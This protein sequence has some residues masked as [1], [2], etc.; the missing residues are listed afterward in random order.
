MTKKIILL[1]MIPLAVA[2]AAILLFVER[3]EQSVLIFFVL[4][5]SLLWAGTIY[6]GEALQAGL[7]M[8]W[9]L[10][11]SKEW[12]REARERKRRIDEVRPVQ[13]EDAD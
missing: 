2:L 12:T 1:N 8:I 13:D 5:A 11:F 7:T 3:E 9:R 6:L 4:V 10:L